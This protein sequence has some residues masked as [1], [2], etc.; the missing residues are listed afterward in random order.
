MHHTKQ[1]LEAI[2]AFQNG[3]ATY[4]VPQPPFKKH[5]DTLLYQV[6]LNLKQAAGGGFDPT[7]ILEAL[8]RLATQV[9]ALTNQG[10]RLPRY[11]EGIIEGEFNQRNFTAHTYVLADPTQQEQVQE[12]DFLVV[13]YP[14]RPPSPYSIDRA[15]LTIEGMQITDGGVQDTL[16]NALLFMLQRV[17]EQWQLLF[18][19]SMLDHYVNS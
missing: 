1:L 14:Q 5:E 15:L 13:Y 11:F 4:P 9:E 19:A 3:N 16:K 12:G 8:T 2:V 17:N 10:K 6:Y 7:P 18:T